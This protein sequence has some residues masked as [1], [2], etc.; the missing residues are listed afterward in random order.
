M[1]SISRGA[2]VGALVVLSVLETSAIAAPKKKPKPASADASSSVAAD[3]FDRQAAASALGGVNLQKCKATNA[4]RGSGH[5]T[6]TFTPSGAVENAQIDKGPW[7][8]TPVAKCMESSFKKVKIPA[9][10]GAP[11][12]VGK[13]FEFA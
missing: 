8:G 13:T 7:I 6:I 1:S 4:A 3:G 2:A 9:F 12:T 10:K 5:V 11:V